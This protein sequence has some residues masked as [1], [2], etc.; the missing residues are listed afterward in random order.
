VR[1]YR[2]AIAAFAVLSMMLSFL[3]VATP[4]KAET[5]GCMPDIGKKLPVLFVHGLNAKGSDWDGFRSYLSGENANVATEA[6]DYS[7]NNT[8]WVTDP[9]IGAALA[10]KIACMATSSREQGGQ[11]K[12]VVVAHSMGGLATRQSISERSDIL[13]DLGIVITIA[14][15]NTGSDTGEFLGD[16]LI[17]L[18]KKALGFGS[19]LIC[20]SLTS[21]ANDAGFSAYPALMTG[22]P[23]ISALANWPNDL[24]VYAIAGDIRPHYDFF[25]A[26]FDGSA[27]GTDT[28]VTVSSALNGASENTLRYEC[29]GDTPIVVLG[30]TKADCEHSTLDNSQAV[31]QKVADVVGKYIEKNKPKPSATGTEVAFKNMKLTLPDNWKYQYEDWNNS[32]SL[33]RVSGC[34]A[35]NCPTVHVRDIEGIDWTIGDAGECSTGEGSIGSLE[36]QG[37]FTMGSKKANYYTIQ[38]C[39]NTHD[40]DYHF[41]ELPKSA[42][43]IDTCGTIVLPELRQILANAKFT[44]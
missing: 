25:F 34:S 20:D 35:P 39:P 42:I 11:G 9:N 14:T 5:P 44:D 36:S 26:E 7:A 16:S 32:L 17:K 24:S 15:P 43:L 28:L 38:V 31:Q 37:T 13:N 33:Y 29:S 8:K 2:G 19:S 12:V 10:D 6:F 4:A 27:S 41:W 21:R 40:E 23:E 18:C 1:L 3:L 30:W 22:S